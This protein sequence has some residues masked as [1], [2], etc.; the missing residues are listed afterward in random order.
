MQN[1]TIEQRITKLLIS[2]L[3]S[4]QNPN[5]P[6]ESYIFYNIDELVDILIKFLQFPYNEPTVERAGKKILG[7]FSIFSE[8][9][10]DTRKLNEAIEDLS[11]GFESFLK[12]IALIK[13][14]TDNIRLR[15]DGINYIGLLHTNLGGLLEGKVSKINLRNGKIPV[16]SAP[17]VT[18]TYN[19]S[20]IRETI[21]NHTRKL[22][23]EVHCTPE[24][25]LS[26]L[27]FL[28]RLITA[29]YIFAL[30]E[31]IQVIRK[32]LDPL[33]IYLVELQDTYC[34]WEH[35]FVILSGEARDR[36]NLQSWP[37]LQVFEWQD[38]ADDIV[39]EELP[40][41]KALEDP[42]FDVR[43]MPMFIQTTV[44][45]LADSHNRFWLIG[46][47]GSGKTTTLQMLAWRR[48]SRILSSGYL[49]WPC[50][51]YIAAGQYDK[52]HSFT[53][54][55]ASLLKIS[56]DQVND[57]L[58]QGKLWLLIDGVNEI[59][60][61]E[62]E[63]AFREIQ[64]ILDLH[65]RACVIITSRKYGFK[66]IL[67]I[68]VYELLPLTNDLI[69]DYL[70]KNM[71]SEETGEKFFERLASSEN[72][73]LNFARNP[74]M[75]RML[76]Q[77][78][79]DSTLP[80]NRGQL[81]RLFTRWVF[82]RE[83]RLRQTKTI[84]KEQS[85][86]S[87]AFSIRSSDKT[88]APCP[89][90]LK[91]IETCL[92]KSSDINTTD[93]FYEL[94]DSRILEIDCNDQV[95][96]FHELVLEYFTAVELRKL[97]FDNNESVQEYYE[98]T[99]WF[100]SLVMLS[101]LLPDANE[102]VLNILPRNI[103]LAARC[104]ASGAIVTPDTTIAIIQ[105]AEKIIL[106]VRQSKKKTRKIRL[107]RQEAYISLF[108]LATQDTLRVVVRSI[109]Q[110]DENFSLTGPLL[111]CERPEIAAL[112]L[113][114]FGLTG[115]KR[116]SQCLSVLKGKFINS[117]IV[118]SP[119]V[120]QAEMILL[121]DGIE[122]ESRDLELIN[123]IGISESIKP[124][125]ENLI[126]RILE[127]CKPTSTLWRTAVSFA[128]NQGII[129]NPV[130]IIK[131]RMADIKEPEIYYSIFIACVSIGETPVSSE[132]ALTTAQQCLDLGLYGLAIRFIAQF[133]H[134]KSIS[135]EDI[136]SH[137]YK[138]ASDGRIGL[139]IQYSRV[140]NEIDFYPL[141]STG[142]DKI[143]E[144]FGPN[145]LDQLQKFSHELEYI[146]REKQ[147]SLYEAI[148]KLG[149]MGVRPRTIRRFIRTLQIEEVFVNVG[150]VRR[151]LEEKG[152]GFI[153]NL[154]TDETV[155]FHISQVI[156]REELSKLKQR[157]FVE[158]VSVDSLKRPGRKR[159][160]NVTVL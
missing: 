52:S 10:L 11:T 152:Y 98:E 51:V 149:A 7:A 127:T 111:R 39:I 150:I 100:E 37:E 118:N 22:R 146:V 76:T 64:W 26:E 67:N 30:E 104:V 141:L 140:Y 87:I 63:D 82:S 20:N 125:V 6:G 36:G 47:P 94:L 73:L 126:C 38:E 57:L 105:Q 65:A 112:R 46:E 113:L 49:T 14:E 124:Q 133:N 60:T 108:E 79:K 131:R 158:Y 97:W 34:K 43:P 4:I 159:A 90:V 122:V 44:I 81:F 72:A 16:L 117:T 17:I 85:L 45:D 66:P 13:Y 84:H 83:S 114:N 157:S 135:E 89:V 59:S 145:Q 27:I 23:N 102:L 123:G 144:E 110:E 29:S 56:E 8:V 68:P 55:A 95:T 18:F 5:N 61:V 129:D 53:E 78:T 25:S 101:D 153:N 160:I 106:H 120:A 77:V 62:Q 24:R 70:K 12:M 138:M 2:E 1:T 9:E 33:F 143:L 80:S 71:V 92:S 142:I 21:Y 75:L 103:I 15:G 136:Q 41:E 28:F 134:K 130:E 3:G 32:K 119:E 156:N 86:A 35:K 121:G 154:I 58:S 74:L 99:K 132:F 48:A 147:K 40:W 91:L 31:N 42:D 19:E 116:I 139:L 109:T 148:L 50:P 151:Y 128:A 107:Y 88:Y 155:F 93:L 137:L 115:R 54:I 96:F 69:L